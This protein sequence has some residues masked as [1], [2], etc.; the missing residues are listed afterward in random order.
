M[1]WLGG[2]RIGN[3]WLPATSG[4]IAGPGVWLPNMPIWLPV[5]LA[6]AS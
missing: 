3:G 5:G 1:M 6:M 4:Y 2:Y